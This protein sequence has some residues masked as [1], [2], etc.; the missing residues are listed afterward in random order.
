MV[1]GENS[2]DQA[3]IHFGPNKSKPLELVPGHLNLWKFSEALPVGTLKD[4][5]KYKYSIRSRAQD[6]M[7]PIRSHI[8]SQNPT[9]YVESDE[10]HLESQAQFDVFNFP[11]DKLYLSETVP[12]A[13]F[14]YLKF[15]LPYV[16][17]SSA[18]EILTKIES[19]RF[20]TLSPKHAKECVNWIVENASGCD[21]T[22]IMR[23]YLCI[24]LSH[25]NI[26][27]FP[28]P[29][30][31]DGKTT[32]ACDRLLQCLNNC[33]HSNFLSTSNLQRLKKIAVILV[34]KS[35]SPG[36]LTLAANFYS[37]LGIEFV[38]DE[39]NTRGLNYEYDA[40]EY[41]KL[42]AAL[43]SQ[44]KNKNGN[45]QAAH[46]PLLHLVLKHAPNLEAVW[47]VFESIDLHLFFTSEGE[48]VDFF[49]NFYQE[50]QTNTADAMLIKFYNIPKTIRCRMHQYLFS[51]LLEFSK[52]YDE[53]HD[54]YAEIFVRLIISEKYLD[55]NR[56][57]EVLTELSKNFRGQNLLLEILEKDGFEQQ[58]R[59]TELPR[60]AEICKS[61]V[62][63]RVIN[64]T[65]SSSLSGVDRIVA[66]Y[67][68]LDAIIQCPLNISNKRL[69]EAVATSVVE[70]MLR[71][72]DIISLLKAF[73]C[74]EKCVHVVQECYISHVK[75]IFK[76]TLKV[77][78]KPSM[79]LYECPRSRY[80]A[81]ILF[82]V[83]YNFAKLY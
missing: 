67:E 16:N 28:L 2:V 74:I 83:C 68:A 33:V 5:F 65:D 59:V 55:K 15:L 58:W 34:G 57:L 26:V 43:L 38:L 72:E 63:T 47:E 60:K 42:V 11:E 23:L 56:V 64:K 9:C 48:K 62:I 51:I 21:V 4:Q 53:L 6:V 73:A 54:E 1:L 77:A 39:K 40:K 25:L 17:L 61:W 12:K 37:Y 36:W 52:S 49:A 35:S 13:I 82:E 31:N 76:P 8:F 27:L 80:S 7:L 75:K 20:I 14:F 10:R 18:V 81:L 30:P 79:A 22:D 32:E 71:N 44:I 24:V 41:K 45:D 3:Y 19:L 69:A 46:Q 50:T 78:K 70:G 29:F 66:T